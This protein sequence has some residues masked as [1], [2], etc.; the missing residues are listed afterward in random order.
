MEVLKTMGNVDL[1]PLLVNKIS[2][3]VPATTN[4]RIFTLFHNTV[5]QTNIAYRYIYD[6]HSILRIIEH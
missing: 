2:Q 4:V 6:R 5:Q 1:F 3:V